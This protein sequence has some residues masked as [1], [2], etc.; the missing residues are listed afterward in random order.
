MMTAAAE[1]AVHVRAAVV[2]AARAE[3]LLALA[4]VS[5]TALFIAAAT[6][7]ALG[8]RAFQARFKVPHERS[9]L[10]FI[11]SEHLSDVLTIY[12]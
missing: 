4:A 1:A 5:A 12:R 10:V 7:A 9:P 3:A 11:L 2:P 6:A 8:V